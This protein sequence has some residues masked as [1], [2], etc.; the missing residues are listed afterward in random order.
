MLYK[1]EPIWELVQICAAELTKAGMVPFTRRD[2]ITCV[3]RKRSNCPEGS[4]NPIIQGITDHLRGG[5]PG[6]VGKDI[7]HSVARGHFII[8]T[9]AVQ[10]RRQTPLA[11]SSRPSSVKHSGKS[12]NINKD[13]AVKLIG[14][15]RFIN[16]CDIEPER[17]SRGSVK[18]YMPQE[19]YENRNH[20]SL[21]QYGKGPFCKFKIPNNYN[22]S[23]VYA[24]TVND[25]VNYIGECVNLS[26]RYNMG[27]GNI[28]PRNCFVGGQDTNCR[29]NNLIFSETKN[30]RHVALWFF[31]TSSYKEVE[32]KLRGH[33]KLKWNRI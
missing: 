23:G 8:R 12:D 22:Q 16:V 3:Q 10:E 27:Y 7:L 20:L 2:L 1:N 5:A 9:K 15:I 30:G 21:S 24:I 6:T 19:R 18:N 26:S 31:H 14:N 32:D 17:N 11:R 33:L 28:S 4:V 25:T 29:I 13:Q